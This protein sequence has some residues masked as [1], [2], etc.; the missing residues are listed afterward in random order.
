MAAHDEELG[1]ACH[2]SDNTSPA[3]CRIPLKQIWYVA[4][5]P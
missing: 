4:S 2:T 5:L 1:T 3:V